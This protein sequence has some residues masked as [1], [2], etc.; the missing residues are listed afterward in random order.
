MASKTH[1]NENNLQII[2]EKDIEEKSDW[3]QLSVPEINLKTFTLLADKP[4]SVKLLFND[5][6]FRST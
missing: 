5:S 2:H 6:T 1:F 3:L 4:W